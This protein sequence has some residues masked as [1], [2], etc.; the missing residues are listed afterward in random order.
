V[1]PWHG[2]LS[3]LWEDCQLTVD[4]PR[5]LLDPWQERILWQ[6]VISEGD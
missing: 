5:I 2:W 4:E 6:N 1:L 3:A